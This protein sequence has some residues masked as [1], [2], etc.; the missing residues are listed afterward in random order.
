MLQESAVKGIVQSSLERLYLALLIAAQQQRVFRWEHI[1]IDDIF[2]LL[3]ESG[4]ARHLKLIGPVRIQSVR[5][6][7]TLNRRVAHTDHCC[8]RVHAPLCQGFRF[9][10]RCQTH[11][12]E[13]IRR[14]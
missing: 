2:E 11:D 13:R 3:N 8:E 1:Q 6:P 12:F 14:V 5:F 9:G 7:N 4:I 10:L